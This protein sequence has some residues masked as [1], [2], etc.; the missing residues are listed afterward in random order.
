MKKFFQSLTTVDG[1]V[2]LFDNLRELIIIL[3][4]IDLLDN[5]NYLGF[6]LVVVIFGFKPLVALSR[7]RSNP[8]G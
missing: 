6:V 8:K 4:L 2:D 3:Y 5:R 7:S 1:W